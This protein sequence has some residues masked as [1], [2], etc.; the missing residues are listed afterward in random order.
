[1][2]SFLDWSIDSENFLRKTPPPYPKTPRTR[3][4]RL[5]PDDHSN[6]PDC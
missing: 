6:L 2:P 3:L 5:L 1:M 4:G